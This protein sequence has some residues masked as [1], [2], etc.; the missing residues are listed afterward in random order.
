MAI[1]RIVGIETEYGISRRSSVTKAIYDRPKQ[2]QVEDTA[3][4]V[5]NFVVGP[6]KWDYRQERE[7]PD[8]DGRQIG[9]IHNRILANGARFYEDHAHPEYSTP[10]CRAPRQVVVCDRAGERI[11]NLAR[12]SANKVLKAEHPD[13]EIV[14][15]KNNVD[16]EGNSFGCHENYLVQRATPWY[17]IREFLMPF[18]VTRQIFTG[19]GKV[20]PNSR[21]PSTTGR[22]RPYST[23]K[24][25]VIDEFGEMSSYFEEAGMKDRHAGLLAEIQALFKD[26]EGGETE[27]IFQLSQRPDFFTR[28]ESLD[29]MSDRGIINTRDEPHA[30]PAKYRRLHVIVGD[31][32]MAPWSTFLK[33][34]TT[35][36]VLDLIEDRH[37]GDEVMLKDPVDTFRS[38]SR[39]QEWKWPVTFQDGRTATA[40]DHQEAYLNLAMRH[41]SHD[42][43]KKEIIERWAS[44][45]DALRRQ[46]TNFL[47][48]RID[49]AIKRRL[50]DMYMGKHDVGLNSPDVAKLDLRYHNINPEEGVFHS[51]ERRGFVDSLGIT[52]EEID[53]TV[54]SPPEDTRA[55]FRGG[56][57]RRF[58]DRVVSANWGHVELT[59]GGKQVTVPLQEPLRGTK[60]LI[61]GALES[62]ENV[63]QLLE[64]L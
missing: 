61:G 49:H 16:S 48:T 38:I 19:A 15:Y 62:S 63:E 21:R 2:R 5:S 9:D 33:V 44:V 53:A 60:E 46:D 51:L 43:I 55:Y 10:E 11:L 45:L 59:A 50:I 14:I 26:Y 8:L 6:T 27:R 32:N 56:L 42:P 25:W 39:D 13:D 29:T 57:L 7:L 34:G 54:K 41:Y 40:L 52:V 47:A 28:E 17:R 35:M 1:D 22:S 18:L 36:L 30:D 24:G 12:A 23:L 37:V 64:K 31:S 20:S 3:L 4:L 58:P